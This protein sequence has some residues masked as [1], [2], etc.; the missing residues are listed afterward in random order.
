MQVDLML[1]AA[2]HVFIDVHGGGL[3]SAFIFQ[4]LWYS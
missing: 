1:V 2:M 3:M 4:I